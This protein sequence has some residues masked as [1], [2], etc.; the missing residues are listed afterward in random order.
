MQIGKNFH[1]SETELKSI[2]NTIVE[3]EKDISGEIRVAFE[4][5]SNSYTGAALTAG[6]VFLLI[7]TLIFLFIED[8]LF[9]NTFIS[10]FQDHYLVLTQFVSFSIGSIIT[11]FSPNLQRAFTSKS[12]MR[13][14]AYE[15]AETIFL[16][17][18]IFATRQRSGI[19][20]FM[21]LLEH[22]IVI[23]PDVGIKAKVKPK[24]W[25]KIAQTI[26]KSFQKHQA[27]DGIQQAVKGCREL[28][29]KYGFEAGPD[30][31][32]ELSNDIILPKK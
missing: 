6:M 3:C 32:N 21:S 28:L 14:S 9:P 5:K 31:L 18:E 22:Q 13:K 2:E 10:Y 16:E 8:I 29:L 25:D 12:Y 11:L 19:L 24:E 26:A 30:D 27:A 20:I 4:Y 1:F 23:L 7:S 15:K 17:K